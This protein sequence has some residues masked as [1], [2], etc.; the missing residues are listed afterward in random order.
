M[1]FIFIYI[2]KLLLTFTNFA[3]HNLAI[4]NYQFI[5][6]VHLNRSQIFNK[7]FLPFLKFAWVTPTAAPAIVKELYFPLAFST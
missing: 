1:N 7:S 3:A 5:Y 2:I 6:F 4:N